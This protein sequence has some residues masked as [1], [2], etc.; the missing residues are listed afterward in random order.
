MWRKAEFSASLLQ[1]SVSD[2]PLKI[3]LTRRF[4]AQETSLIIINVNM[5]NIFVESVFFFFVK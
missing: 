1:S 4:A 2:D 3:T 5:L